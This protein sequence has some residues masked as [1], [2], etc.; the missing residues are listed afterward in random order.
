MAGERGRRG[1]A[2]GMGGHP[3]LP[4]PPHRRSWPREW[5]T[6]PPTGE[7]WGET[8]LD[9]KVTAGPFMRWWLCTSKQ[10]DGW[11][12]APGSVRINASL[13]LVNKLPGKAR[14]SRFLELQ[15]SVCLGGISAWPWQLKNSHRQLGSAGI[16]PRHPSLLWTPSPTPTSWGTPQ[17]AL[18]A[19]SQQVAPS[20][21][22]LF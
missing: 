3:P 8:F 6:A 15:A 16:W 19:P 9:C 17:P 18:R 2:G 7:G 5:R 4:Q 22:Q 1:E 13:R 14:E 10:R 12:G 20:C 21:Y 11:W